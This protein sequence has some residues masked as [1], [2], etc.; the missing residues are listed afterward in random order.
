D[1]T[2]VPLQFLNE[3]IVIFKAL[4]RVHNFGT[5]RL[6]DSRFTCQILWLIYVKDA[7]A[8]HYNFKVIFH[9]RCHVHGGY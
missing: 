3:L 7:C 2:Q 5:L 6:S 8:T 1:G 4:N 9:V